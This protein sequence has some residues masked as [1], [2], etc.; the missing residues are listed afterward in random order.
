MTVSIMTDAGVKGHTR[1]SFDDGLAVMA[2]PL[3]AHI[4]RAGRN[5][6]IACACSLR[7]THGL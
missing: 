2:S 3:L 4:A 6:P 5:A 1:E 7:L